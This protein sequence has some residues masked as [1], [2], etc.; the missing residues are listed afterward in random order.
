MET[1][2]KITLP[3]AVADLQVIER[4][5]AQCDCIVH[6]DPKF[7]R[8]SVAAYHHDAALHQHKYYALFDL[9]VLS[10]VLDIARGN[11][12]SESMRNAAAL[13]AF[14]MSFDGII[15]PG[16][17]AQEYSSIN[18]EV[19]TREN[20][21]L[22]RQADNAHP[23]IY[24]SITCNRCAAVSPEDL[25]NV[26]KHSPVRFRPYIAEPYWQHYGALLKLGILL[27]VKHLE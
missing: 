16:M 12:A 8:Y 15:E 24:A 11:S 2:I 5:L 26:R 22:F 3:Y 20:I 4:R 7:P 9:N 10:N 25:P 27:G 1:V 19:Q 17:S 18:G 21:R 23:A 6:Y 13:M 14:L